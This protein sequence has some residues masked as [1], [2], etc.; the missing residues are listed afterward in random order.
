MLHPENLL[1]IFHN[2]TLFSTDSGRKIKI[3]P[4]Y[5]QYRA[6]AEALHRLQHNPT[7]QDGTED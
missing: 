4:R 5:P 3:I 7:R 6:V 2:F 1:D